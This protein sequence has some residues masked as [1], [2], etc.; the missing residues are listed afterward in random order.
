M[1]HAPCLALATVVVTAMAIPA[2]A[3]QDIECRAANN[4]AW[5]SFAAGTPPGIGAITLSMGAGD[6]HW[7]TNNARGGTLVQVLQAFDDGEEIK[8]DVT[9]GGE[10]AASLRLS[11]ADEGGEGVF[12]G[13]LR[14][15]GV[16]AWPV[17]CGGETEKTEAE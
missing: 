5:M 11:F 12:G 14:I 7:S 17:V 4:A 16:G 10:L 9:A 15:H 6:G 1:Q 13:I 3:T 2:S 8:I